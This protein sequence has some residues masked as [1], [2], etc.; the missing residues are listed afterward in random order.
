MKIAILG[1]AFDPPHMGHYLV[2]SQVKEQLGMD[3]VWLM[4]CY[5]YFPEFP[6]KFAKITP[7][8]ERHKMASYFKKFGSKKLSFTGI[9][10]TKKEAEE[11][12]KFRKERYNRDS[13]II[14]LGGEYLS[15]SN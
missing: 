10:D 4:T 5:S 6:V 3:E 1:G 9:S 13:K 15:Y 11:I 7:F 8:E 14:K 2:A 12:K